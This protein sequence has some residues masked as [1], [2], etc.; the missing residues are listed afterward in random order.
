MCRV[1]LLNGTSVN[2]MSVINA[3]NPLEEDRIEIYI[4]YDYISYIVQEGTN[5]L[6]KG[7]CDRF[8]YAKKFDYRHMLLI[9]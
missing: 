9:L 1:A 2:D 6:N 7:F 3:I 5:M 4:D 8:Q